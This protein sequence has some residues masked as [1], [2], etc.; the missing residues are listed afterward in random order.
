M[1]EI[2][3][4]NPLLDWDELPAFAD[5]EAAHVEPAMRSVLDAAEAELVR[6]EAAAPNTWDALWGPLERLMDGVKRTWG[7]VTHLTAVRNSPQ[8]REAHEKMQ[9]EVVAFWNRLG[10]SR[11]LFDT[12][13]RLRDGDEWSGY[14]QPQ[15][16]II[17]S[18]VRDGK[19]AGVG[20]DGERREE[21]TR[22]SKALAELSTRFSNNVLDAVKGYSLILRDRDEVAGL[23]ESL[24]ALASEAAR[25]A[26]HDG[27]TAQAGPWAITL[28]IPSFLPF[29]KHSRRRDLRE[30][31]YRAYITRAAGGEFDNS[32]IITQILDL[33]RGK[34]RM[35]GFKTHAEVSLSRKMAGNVAAVDRLLSDLRDAAKPAGVKDLE[36]L[37]ELARSQ[38][39]VEADNMMNWDV[40]FWAE[41]HREERFDL[42]DEQLRPYFPLPGVLKG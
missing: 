27:A 19:L 26:G 23:P 22:M 37:R 21:F 31:L 11:P 25:A 40:A 17:E 13:N 2:F 38:G 16:R 4:S 6:L 14:D 42:N 18:A 7:L 28:D 15:R 8:L 12:Y 39:A 20:L 41:R 29:M 34:A 33:R 24:L 10:Q 5:I 9:G 30:K 35:L 1:T 3:V 32:D 36:E